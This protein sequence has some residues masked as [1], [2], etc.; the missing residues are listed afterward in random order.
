MATLGLKLR[1]EHSNAISGWLVPILILGATI[2]DTTL[3]TI[4]RSRRGLIP[5]TTPGKDHTAHRLANLWDQRGAVLAMYSL[6]AITGGAAV[7]V[8]Y[9][10]PALALTIAAIA[11]VL[12]L[13]GVAMLER[14]PYEA[15]KPK[16][17]KAVAA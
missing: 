5:F 1:L 7:L 11:V 6:G 14:A 9:L 17:A 15:Q 2:F 12:T 13:G 8:T 4:S 10:S 16:I 3:I